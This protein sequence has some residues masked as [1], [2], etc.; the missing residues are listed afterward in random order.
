MNENEL[1]AIPAMNT[2]HANLTSFSFLRDPLNHCVTNVAEK[3]MEYSTTAE[4]S[5]STTSRTSV[6]SV[7]T[8]IVFVCSQRIGHKA[9]QEAS[10]YNSLFYN[11]IKTG[12]YHKCGTEHSR[13]VHRL[14]RDT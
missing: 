8:G 2:D 10:L 1:Q 9:P 4:W 11:Y 3:R 7:K 6:G 12:H 13:L 5:T 14:L